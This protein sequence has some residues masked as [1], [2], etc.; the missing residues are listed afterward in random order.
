MDHLQQ[1][2]WKQNST[3]K[4]K[5]KIRCTMVFVPE[6]PLKINCEG[7]Y[8]QMIDVASRPTSVSNNCWH[9][10]FERIPSTAY[11]RMGRL[12]LPPMPTVSVVSSSS[13]S[14]QLFDKV[15]G[16]TYFDDTT[17]IGRCMRPF[18]TF[19]IELKKLWSTNVLYINEPVAYQ[20]QNPFP[21]HDILDE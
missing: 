18:K 4:T 6:S 9:V 20:Y 12:F 11:R 13:P 17:R 21:L 7:E 19:T 14:P 1:S 15:T 3:I 5:L 8:A 2:E 10:S 16:R